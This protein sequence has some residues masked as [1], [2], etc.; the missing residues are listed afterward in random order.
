[1]RNNQAE[2]EGW[3]RLLVTI[4]IVGVV[5]WV[6]ASVGGWL[7]TSFTDVGNHINSTNKR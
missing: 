4:L 7:K 3:M 1:M 6:A 5:V 2:S